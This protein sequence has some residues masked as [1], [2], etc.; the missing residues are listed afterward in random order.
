MLSGAIDKGKW[1]LMSKHYKMLRIAIVTPLSVLQD[2]HNRP[3]IVFM[4]NFRGSVASEELCT[5]GSAL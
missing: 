5:T 2:A 4:L 1:E 3:H